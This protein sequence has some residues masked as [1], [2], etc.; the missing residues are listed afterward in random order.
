[1]ALSAPPPSLAFPF[2]GVEPVALLAHLP[3]P[4]QQSMSMSY[5][6]ELDNNMEF[7]LLLLLL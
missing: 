6:G 4:V 7:H 3:Q 5:M 2:P 1:M